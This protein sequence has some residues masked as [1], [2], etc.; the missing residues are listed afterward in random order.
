ME[1]EED[2]KINIE[3]Q[4]IVR[5]HKKI[6]TGGSFYAYEGIPY[7]ATPLRFQVGDTA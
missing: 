7:A 4:G 3:L 1:L 2:L 5:G 6:V